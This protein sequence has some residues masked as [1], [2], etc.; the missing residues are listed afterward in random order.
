MSYL[1]SEMTEIK[2]ILP[3]IPTNDLD[4]IE[5]MLAGAIGA[6]GM[7]SSVFEEGIQYFTRKKDVMES[8][9]KRINIHR[10]IIK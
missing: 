7:D 8:I 2:R 6:G 9:E 5:Y 4:Y 10:K 3:Y 1:D